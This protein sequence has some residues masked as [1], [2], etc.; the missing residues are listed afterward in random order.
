MNTENCTDSDDPVAAAIDEAEE[1]RD[2]LDGLVEKTATDSS[3]PFAPDAL[4]GLA[5]LKKEDRAAFEA[6]RSKLKKAGCRVTAL[7]KSIPEENG[8][9]RAR[10]E[11]GGH[12]DRTGAI[13]R[14]VPRAGR[15]RLRRPRHQR[16]S[17]NLADPPQG[18]SPLARPPLLRGNG[19]RTQ[20]GGAAIGAERDR[21]QG[22]FRCARARRLCPRRRAGWPALSRPLRRDMA[23]SRD[24]RHWLARHRQSAGAFPPRRRDE[25]PSSAGAGRIGRGAANL[26]QCPFRCRLRAGG[27][28]GACRPAQSWPLSGDRAVGRAGI[29]EVH[30][31]RDPAGAARSRT[32]RPCA[33]CRATIAICSSQPA[34][35]TCWPSTTC[36]A[37]R[38]GFP[39]RCAGWPPA[40]DLRCAS[41]TPIRTRC[42]STPPGR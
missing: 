31:L 17:R 41:S 3:A 42:C 39:T 1:V 6:L 25:G 21:G 20:L 28:V 10:P 40:A 34:T 22:A 36:R 7:D 33:P 4:E 11:A 29:G 14:A 38:R 16:P 12:P 2:P 27:R 37:C 18:L 30:P 5:T 13:R 32:Q 23:G 19:R 8:G 24:R 26:P 15:H 35:A 9:R